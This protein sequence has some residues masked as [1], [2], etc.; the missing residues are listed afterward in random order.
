MSTSFVSKLSEHDRNLLRYVIKLLRSHTVKEVDLIS[1][2]TKQDDL[3]DIAI[4]TI[5]SQ[6]RIMLIFS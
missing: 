4:N 1:L 6:L 5:F 3:K 2:L